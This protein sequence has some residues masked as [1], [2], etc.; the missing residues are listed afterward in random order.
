VIATD[1]KRG[2]FAFG[3]GDVEDVAMA[4]GDNRGG[5]GRNRVRDR[6]RRWKRRVEAMSAKRTEATAFMT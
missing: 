3:E 1:A 2:D 5:R 6:R 4:A